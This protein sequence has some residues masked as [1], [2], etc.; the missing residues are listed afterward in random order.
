MDSFDYEKTSGSFQV[1]AISKI[2]DILIAR[3]SAIQHVHVSVHKSSPDLQ[4][5]AKR[6]IRVGSS[7]C[8][9]FDLCIG[10]VCLV[11]EQRWVVGAHEIF[12]FV[13]L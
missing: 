11:Q 7:S 12:R 8:L 6:S 9:M 4:T 13:K 1:N 3:P 5:V 2:K 10:I